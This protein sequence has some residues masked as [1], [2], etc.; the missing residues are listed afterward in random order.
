M[1]PNPG[2]D[3]REQE[4]EGDVKRVLA[5]VDPEQP[6]GAGGRGHRDHGV[7]VVLDVRDHGHLVAATWEV[8]SDPHPTLIGRCHQTMY[9]DWL[10]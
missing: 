8:V 7:I 9:C 2:E 6:G 4:K 5:Q 3:D 1:G 10:T